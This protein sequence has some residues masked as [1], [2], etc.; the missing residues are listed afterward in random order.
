MLKTFL[1]VA[2]EDTIYLEDALKI[3]ERQHNGIEIF[4]MTSAVEVTLDINGKKIPF[5]PLN[6]LDA[7]G[8]D[9]DILLVV[10]AK[11]IG[12]S[13]ITQAARQ[14]NLPEEKLLG[15]W[16]ACIPGF[17]LDKYRRLQR[18]QMSIF[19]INCF[20]GCISNML[21]LPFRSPFVNL[22]LSESDFVKF[23][24]APRIYLEYSP[25]F[26]KIFSDKSPFPVL[27]LGDVILN[28][29]HYKESDGAIAKWNERKQ[30]INWYNLAVIAY[31]SN[32][33]T[34]EQF[35]TLP[36][37]KKICFV[38]FKSDLDSAWY[39]N[40]EIDKVAKASYGQSI[41][42]R[43]DGFGWGRVIYYDLF[44]MLLYGKKTPLVDM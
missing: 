31:A 40:L 37:G 21:G 3:L 25:Y 32:A 6:K 14:L 17:T 24:R 29:K 38:P 7:V 34:L 1:W 23:M 43:I 12:M 16:I 26:E 18:S 20:G 41:R 13:K 22:F 5:V 33:E 39:I 30:R 4:G 9:Y 15:D 19:S 42:A 11:K 35:D 2:S 28:M 8:G 44:D 36:Y 27:S 10:G